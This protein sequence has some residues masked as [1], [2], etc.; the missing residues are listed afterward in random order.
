[1]VKAIGN[2]KELETS[3]QN[4]GKI[5]LKTIKNSIENL[6]MVAGDIENQIQVLKNNFTEN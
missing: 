5:G 1:L 2:L 3:S 6:E 4:R